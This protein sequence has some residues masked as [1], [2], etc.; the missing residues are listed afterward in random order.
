MVEIRLASSADVTAL[1]ELLRGKA[2]FDGCP[3]ALAA[4]EETLRDHLFADSPL[5]HALLAE[6]EGRPVGLATYYPVYSSFRARPALWLDDLFVFEEFRSR[7]VGAALVE[8]L[9]N[10]ARE[11]GCCRI[12]WTVA[13]ANTRGIAF[14]ER[15]GA[16]IR[17]ATAL[18][19]LEV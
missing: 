11:R 18:C 14:Y 5:A 13:R 6:W 19:R 16:Q 7:R 10:V 12:D 15:M 2:E 9:V 1:L 17:E 3:E 4:T 8:A